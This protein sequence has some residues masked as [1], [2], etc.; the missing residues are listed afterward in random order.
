MARAAAPELLPDTKALVLGTTQHSDVA[1]DGL[2]VVAADLIGV[3]VVAEL[4]IASAA[5]AHGLVVQAV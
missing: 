3:R 5:R 1:P 4:D 2:A